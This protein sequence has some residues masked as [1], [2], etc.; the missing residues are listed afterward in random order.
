[1][2][3]EEMITLECLDCW[4]MGTINATL[5]SSSIDNA[6]LSVVFQDVKASFDLALLVN[7]KQTLTIPIYERGGKLK[8]SETCLLIR[9]EVT[10]QKNPK[11]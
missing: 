5:A 1:M 6:E 4:T 2:N 11:Y 8:V 9:G 3:T 10:A 7:A